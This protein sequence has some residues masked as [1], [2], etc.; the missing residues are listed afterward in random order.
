MQSGRFGN[1]M[2][3]FLGFIQAI[4]EFPQYD[5]I[6]PYFSDFNTGKLVPLD[7]YFTLKDVENRV[8]SW[9]DVDVTSLK[10][11][12]ICSKR[13]KKTCFENGW[14]GQKLG[15]YWKHALKKKKFDEEYKY[16]ERSQL[17]YLRRSERIDSGT[18]LAFAGNFAGFPMPLELE[19]MQRHLTWSKGVMDVVMEHIPSNHNFLAVHLRLGSDWKKFCEKIDQWEGMPQQNL[20][21]EFRQCYRHG[22]PTSI[23]DACFPDERILFN[24]IQE[25]ANAN[26]LKQIYLATEDRK[27]I[28]HLM[29][30]L[31]NKRFT[32]M[33]PVKSPEYPDWVLESALLAQGAQ[34]IGSCGSSFTAHV[35]RE[36][37]HVGLR[38]T[39]MN[40]YFGVVPEADS[41][42]DE[43]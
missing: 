39:K 41:V 34:F 37:T 24:T 29:F 7:K 35:V 1:Q 38:P 2:E 31:E 18:V 33:R 16:D 26:V 23:K 27:N 5:I 8:V 10:F 32:V 30:M 11:V 15:H 9:N 19:S 6:L 4:V 28:Q 40:H 17:D 43:L 22:T 36:R 3:H 20:P 14:T 21:M 13:S 25:V 42:K 12:G